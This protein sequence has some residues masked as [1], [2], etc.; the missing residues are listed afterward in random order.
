MNSRKA[1][2]LKKM[3]IADGLD[4]LDKRYK[5]AKKLYK[6]LNKHEKGMVMNEK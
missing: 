1:K 2:Q 6:Q 5:V 3:L 4:N